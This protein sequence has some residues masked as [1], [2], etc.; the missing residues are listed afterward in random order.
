MNDLDRA[1]IASGRS[2]AALP[3]LMRRLAEGELWFAASANERI[4]RL[5]PFFVPYHPEVEG[6]VMELKNGMKLPFAMFEDEEGPH[7]PLFSSFERV[8]EAMKRARFA[9]RTYSA[10]SM[11]AKQ[12]LEM[13]GKA[14]LRAM[15]N[16]GCRETGQMVIP[17]NMM[18][19][20]ADGSAFETE[21]S[22]QGR[23]QEAVDIINP[24]DY[25]TDLIQPAFEIL[26]KHRNFRAAWIFGRGKGQPT[27]VGGRRY[28]FLVLMEPRDAA[29]FHEFNLVVQ[30]AAPPHEADLGYLDENNAAYIAD[31]WRQVA[32]F[33]TAPDYERPPGAK[34]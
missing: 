25:P 2:K 17:A 3:E 16:K 11:P 20:I 18:R 23:T 21:A 24:A 34:S 19:G 5:T 1:I 28:Q 10:G 9:A 7:V 30:S 15:L 27:A 26:R 31:L 8:R 22:P 14:D 33:Y 29:I 4:G 12:A 13:I 6:G 32:A